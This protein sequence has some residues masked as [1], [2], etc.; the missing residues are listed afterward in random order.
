MI[1]MKLEAGVVEDGQQHAF[2]EALVV[3]LRRERAAFVEA[4][5][6][7]GMT[8]EIKKIRE[9][10]TRINELSRVIRLITEAKGVKE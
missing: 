10:A 5:V 1:D 9:L 8:G 4:M 2:V 7:H 3:H 6:S